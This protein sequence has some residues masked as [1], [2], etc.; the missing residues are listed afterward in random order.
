MDSLARASG[1]ST[2]EDPATLVMSTPIAETDGR[3]HRRLP[4]GPEPVKPTPSRRSALE[5]H[6]PG[7]R[8]APA[9]GGG[10]RRRH[11]PRPPAPAAGPGSPPG[12]GGVASSRANA[13]IA[14]GAGPP[15]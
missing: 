2:F 14:S 10:R 9:P 15:N 1:T 6:S 8:A 7:A 12:G 5:R 3:D 4:I 11:A 13:I